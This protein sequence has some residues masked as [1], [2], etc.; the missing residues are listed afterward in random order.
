MTGKA[1]LSNQWS[2]HAWTVGQQI[3]TPKGNRW[4]QAQKVGQGSHGVAPGHGSVGPNIDGSTWVAQGG[5][6][7]ITLVGGCQSLISP[8]ARAQR[9]SSLNVLRLHRHS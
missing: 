8:D 9:K 7:T 3:V 2:G 6:G 1:P 4:V 5:A